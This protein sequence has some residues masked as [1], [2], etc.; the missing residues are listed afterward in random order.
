MAKKSSKKDGPARDKAAKFVELGQKRVGAA[1][2]K[3]RLVRNLANRSSYSFDKEQADAIT[4]ALTAEVTALESKF[5]TAL[6]AP[7]ESAA[8]SDEPLFKF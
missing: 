2:A 6:K 3:I 8:K 1:I 5:A 7:D 4:T